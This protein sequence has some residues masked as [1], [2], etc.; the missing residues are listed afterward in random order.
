LSLEAGRC[1]TGLYL[2]IGWTHIKWSQ[3]IIDFSFICYVF[4]TTVKPVLSSHQSEA[5][6][7]AA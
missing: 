1:F 7:V 4:A 5:Q 6:E 3:N 2:V